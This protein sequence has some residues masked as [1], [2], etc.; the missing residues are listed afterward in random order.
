MCVRRSTSVRDSPYGLGRN[1][2]AAH[3]GAMPS[4]VG[5]GRGG[6]GGK[7]GGKTGWIA[8]GL[9]PQARLAQARGGR[10]RS[11]APPPPFLLAAVASLVHLTLARDRLLQSRGGAYAP[12]EPEFFFCLQILGRLVRDSVRGVGCCCWPPRA[13]IKSA[14]RAHH[15]PRGSRGRI[16]RT[17]HGRSTAPD[18]A[19]AL[20]PALAR[21]RGA[22][23][24]EMGREG[25]RP[26]CSN[27]A[28]KAAG[29]SKRGGVLSP[30]I[31]SGRPRPGRHPGAVREPTAPPQVAAELPPHRPRRPECDSWR[32]ARP[33]RL[34]GA[35]AGKQ[36]RRGHVHRSWGQRTGSKKW[37]QK[38]GGTRSFGC[39]SFC[40]PQLF[41]VSDLGLET[42]VTS[43]AVDVLLLLAVWHTHARARCPWMYIHIHTR[44]GRAPLYI[45]TRNSYALGPAAAAPV[46]SPSPCPTPL[47]AAAA[48]AASACSIHTSSSSTLSGRPPSIGRPVRRTIVMR[49]AGC[50]HP[51]T[52]RQADSMHAYLMHTRARR[53]P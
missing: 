37:K 26:P 45:H 48:A 13:T 2:G 7:W 42:C 19:L 1:Q 24:G 41:W 52:T 33:S 27:R 39:G 17:A 9:G 21:R 30:G 18:V 28:R 51:S 34:C 12:N 14:P 16:A 11:G 22:G 46:P 38:H 23:G 53:R 40:C 31:Q 8:R 49:P 25:K 36:S 32:R 15:H 6:C 43:D 50:G 4:T 29:R 20:A 44:S 10:R 35:R 47:G 3:P 5:R